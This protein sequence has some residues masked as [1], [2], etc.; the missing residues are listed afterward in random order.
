MLRD[1]PI[2]FD[3]V[4][5][6]AWVNR[7]AIQR[8]LAQA[9]LA[10]SGVLVV[11]ER[12]SGR[13]SLLNWLGEDLRKKGKSVV[14]VNAAL[15]EDATGFLDLV[16]NGLSRAHANS[17]LTSQLT[18]PPMSIQA[19]E[20]ILLQEKARRLR[21]APE[22]WILVDDLYEK[23]VIRTV[24]GGLRD[25]LWESGHHWVVSARPADRGA[26]LS[27]PADAFFAERIN[28]PP[29]TRRELERFAEHAGTGQGKRLESL[30][31]DA[32]YPREAVRTL[33]QIDTSID[34]DDAEAAL[35]RAVAAVF[36]DVLALRRP[37][38]PDDPEL[39]AA[40]GLSEVTLRKYLNRLAASGYL[41]D[42]TARS[43]AP[44]R[45]RKIYAPV[46]RS[47]A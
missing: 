23:K 22:A 26:F 40:S 44:G 9:A 19:S 15:V 5:R 36:Q 42:E 38:T 13:T 35:G 3:A 28:L 29:L 14:R 46:S 34:T 30:A 10:A 7:P 24:F 32:T 12:G 2:L 6:E 27:P 21:A 1:S 17:N 43:G 20:T 25:F 8:R 45:P 39:L 16:I 33:L 11:G 47:A 31:R 18:A 41:E 4:D 37:V